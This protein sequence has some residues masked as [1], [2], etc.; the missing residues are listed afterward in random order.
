MGEGGVVTRT[1]AIPSNSL[2]H[3]LLDG[4]VEDFILPAVG[5]IHLVVGEALVLA[6]REMGLA[7]RLVRDNARAGLELDIVQRANTGGRN[8]GGPRSATGWETGAGLKGDEPQCAGGSRCVNPAE[9]RQAGRAGCEAGWKQ[10]GETAVA[11]SSR[12]Q[13]D[14]DCAV[15][16]TVALAALSG[17][18]AQSTP[19][20]PDKMARFA[21]AL[22]AAANQ[23][24]AARS[25]S[26]VGPA[27][28]AR[29]NVVARGHGAPAASETS[30]AAREGP[31]GICLR[32]CCRRLGRC[33]PPAGAERRLRRPAVLAKSL[34]RA[35]PLHQHVPGSLPPAGRARSGCVAPH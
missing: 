12:K 20:L 8:K 23:P 28:F 19:V 30:A 32:G 16:P 15:P 34:V 1:S 2:V 27:K 11:G 31:L 6:Q 9:R 4:L 13:S 7:G 29:P 10:A 17:T 25:S 14:Q 24:A 21:R 3:H 35:G 33:L 18:Q 22:P 26:Q 5:E